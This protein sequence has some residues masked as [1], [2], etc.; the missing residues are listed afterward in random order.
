[1][2]VPQELREK[3]EAEMLARGD[4]SSRSMFGTVAYLARGRMFAFWV[5]DGLVA[6]VPDRTRQELLDR[7]AGVMFQGPQGRG[8]G[9]WLHV[10]LGRDED[11]EACSAAARDSYEYVRGQPSRRPAKKRRR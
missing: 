7:K 11:L 5:G 8:F 2:P 9:E 4:V 1:M 10:P 3:V 6:K